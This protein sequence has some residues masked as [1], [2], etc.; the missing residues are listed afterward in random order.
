MVRKKIRRIPLTKWNEYKNIINDFV[1]V[2]AGYQKFL[3]LRKV[4]QPNIWG[5]D[6]TPLYE[7]I[8]LRGL[9]HYNY[10][11]TWPSNVPYPSGEL[12][13]QN[14]VLY[15][16]KNSLKEG[17]YLNEDTYW[18]FNWAEDRFILDGKVYKPAGDTEVAQAYDDALHFFL[19]M[20]RE[21]PGESRELLK[22]YKQY[23][24]T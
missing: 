19:I 4:N 15:I 23:L 9:L 24:T 16:T 3:W 2:D 12:E 13:G 11:K 10:I 21:D 22:L 6:Q 20:K 1:E 8:L 18:E 14:Q 7:P 5:E 17:G